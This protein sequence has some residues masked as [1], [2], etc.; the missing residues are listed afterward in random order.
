MNSG[1]GVGVAEDRAAANPHLRADV[2]LVEALTII[3]EELV[4]NTVALSGKTSPPSH[5]GGRRVIQGRI[6]SFQ[7]RQLWRVVVTDVGS[8]RV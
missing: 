3:V 4:G 5:Q 8:V 7:S 6:G 1:V 2:T